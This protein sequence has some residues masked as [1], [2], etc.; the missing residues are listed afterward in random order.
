[1]VWLKKLWLGGILIVLL[2]YFYCKYSD[3]VL[4]IKNN[5]YFLFIVVGVV[6][7]IYLLGIFLGWYCFFDNYCGG[8]SGRFFWWVCKY[9]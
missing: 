3:C 6:L 5:K 8:Y 4:K 7:S 2:V 9:L 1:M